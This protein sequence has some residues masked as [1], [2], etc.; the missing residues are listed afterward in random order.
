MTGFDRVMVYKFDQE[1]NGVVIAED[2]RE[3]VDTFMDLRFPASDIPRQARELYTQN[4]L[5]LI[6]NVDYQPVA[7]VPTNNPL[8]NA[9]LDLSFAALRSVSPIHIR[10]S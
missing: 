4:W 10:L 3:D 9:P 7:I 1:W 8:T 2:R 6:A 5:R